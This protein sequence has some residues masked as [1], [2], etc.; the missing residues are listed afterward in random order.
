MELIKYGDMLDTYTDAFEDLK[1][2]AIPVLGFDFT[3]SKLA[4]DINAKI[5]SISSKLDR[6]HQLQ[7]KSSV[8]PVTNTTSTE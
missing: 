7:A 6:I 3:Q 8:T 2:K 4:S 1:E 5:D